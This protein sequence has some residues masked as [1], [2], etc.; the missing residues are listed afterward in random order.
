MDKLNEILKG[1][2]SISLSEIEDVKLMDRVDTK[3]SFHREILNDVLTKLSDE[4]YVL[5]INDNR[6]GSYRSLY[7]DYDN[8]KFYHDHHNRKNHRFKIRFREYIDSQLYFLE[9]KEKRKGRTKKTRIQVNSF[10]EELSMKSKSFIDEHLPVS[11]L[12]EASL[13]N[14]YKRITLVS[15]NKQERLTLD[16][17]LSYTWEGQEKNYPTLVIAEVKQKKRDRTSHF[18]KVMR[19][20]EIRP[21]R[22]SKY[23]IGTIKM[24]G[25]KKVKYNRFKEELLK[26]KLVT[27][28]TRNR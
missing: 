7:F 23:C 1:F 24:H 19:S 10:E 2:E 9:I 11:N 8:F 4:Y 6:Y 13:W 22:I 21:Y 17:D 25:K 28:A 3:F 18:F 5:T 27:N 14:Q 15:K 26:L 12:L 20:L 16:I